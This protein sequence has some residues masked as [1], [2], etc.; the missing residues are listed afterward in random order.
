MGT[1]QVQVTLP[2]AKFYYLY[3]GRAHG[4]MGTLRVQVTLPQTNFTIFIMVG[5]MG[6]WAHGEFKSHCHRQNVTIFI[7]LGT[8]AH[9]YLVD[10]SHVHNE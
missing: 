10:H 2:Q 1:L 9:G 7:M 5:H 3:N 8:W 4:H 6:T